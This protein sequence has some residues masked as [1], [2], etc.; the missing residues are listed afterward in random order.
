MGQVWLAWD[1]MLQVQ[2]AVKL[3]SDR[4]AHD[5]RW[6]LDV[7]REARNLAQLGH[8]AIARLL[9][10]VIDGDR[11]GL[12][13]EYIRGRT[14]REILAIGEPLQPDE[15]LRIARAVAEALDEAHRHPLR[16]VHCDL[17]P[18]NVMLADDG[19]V[20]V[21]DWGISRRETPDANDC[22][23]HLGTP[24]YASPEAIL[25]HDAASRGADLF[26]FG[27]LLYELL[28]G[29]RAFQGRDGDE[30]IV[31]T[32]KV[33]PD[34]TLLPPS[35]PPHVAA[36][37][38][39]LLDK[40]P[41]LRAGDIGEVL[42]TLR[43]EP[44]RAVVRGRS[45]TNL[46][47]PT[48][49]FIGR[50][51]ELSEARAALGAHRLVVLHGLG[52]VG[53]TAL[54][55]RLAH[56]LASDR[57]LAAFPDGIWLAR[58]G[59]LREP[60]L[61]AETVARAVQGD[62]AAQPG[63]GRGL[64]G[65][66]ADASALIVIDRCEHLAESVG[67]FVDELIER[68]PDV[69]VIA[70]SRVPL[71]SRDAAIVRL[72]PM[73]THAPGARDTSPI[74]MDAIVALDSVRLF[75][76]RAQRSDAAF[77]PSERDLRTIAEI[78]ARL[79]GMPLSIDLAAGWLSRWSLD[80]LAVGLDRVL[81]A[82]SDDA[83][84]AVEGMVA[85]M[86]DRLETA[87]RELLGRL[88]VFRGGWSMGAAIE[89]CVG[90][91]VTAS[92]IPELLADLVDRS[93]VEAERDDGGGRRYRM[94]APVR[95]MLESV[96]VP[97]A[98]TGARTALAA[99]HRRWCRALAEGD[100]H[101]TATALPPH[102]R[103]DT[104]LRE[105]PNLR[106]AIEGSL[107]DGAIDDAAA[108]AIALHRFW[109]ARG[110]HREGLRLI[111]TILGSGGSK[112]I[113]A[114]QVATSTG[115]DAPATAPLTPARLHNA[116]GVLAWSAGE[117]DR[118]AGH[119]ASAA[120]HLQRLGASGRRGLV[121][122]RINQGLVAKDR[123]DVD[124]ALARFDEARTLANELGDPQAAAQAEL[125]AAVVL[126][127]SGRDDRAAALLASAIPVL[128]GDHAMQEFLAE[129]LAMRGLGA[130]EHGTLANA[131]ADLARCV[132]MAR[133]LGSLAKLPHRAAAV[134]LLA[135]R[136]GDAIEAAILRAAAGRLA[137]ELGV[138]VRL[139]DRPGASPPDSL[140]RSPRPTERALAA[141]RRRG[142]GLTAHAL[143]DLAEQ[144]ARQ[145]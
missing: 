109:Y 40:N 3:P 137:R 133:A 98:A 66:L 61:V 12:V 91:A 29:E 97:S 64:F 43:M 39:R 86:I 20:K 99:H 122:V 1:T 90:G 15:A 9:D 36:L 124:A 11:C 87:Q 24:G 49:R 111:E 17:K 107:R 8:S 44:P 114:P 81:A 101:R 128:E 58:L 131:A 59:S 16:I 10:V 100:E 79:D 142:E 110:L 26:A 83:A 69:R 25:G 82:R 71:P 68:C 85:W 30:R 62:G 14:L 51:R 116:A 106:E 136:R 102:D 13:M 38:R 74:T 41:R 23:A 76:D 113:G 22:P 115:D 95:A 96:V 53:K 94:L 138:H 77:R 18:S 54:A 126:H 144:V 6:R 28:S 75:L 84:S 42:P 46:P 78:T 63:D 70:T 45:P 129:A 73:A 37:L 121:G 80:D 93:L 140:D 141:A 117:L 139:L 120:A 7:T 4:W 119:H 5:P 92:A 130:L 67:A 56:D 104:L 34:W 88:T 132:A 35:T 108:M 112:A 55:I 32:L 57:L 50:E 143:F 27:A 19:A 47:A 135:E 125:N 21:L 134:A 123:P 2:R 33:D 72:G 145:A 65:R 60:A 48:F 52:G 105:W 118:A 127:E 31:S 103:L 89:V